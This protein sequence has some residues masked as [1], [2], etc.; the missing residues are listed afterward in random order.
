MPKASA[1]N[2]AT[3]KIAEEVVVK[4]SVKQARYKR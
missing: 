4:F 1:A 3:D 2:N